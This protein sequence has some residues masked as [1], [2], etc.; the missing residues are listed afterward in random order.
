M[1]ITENKYETNID[2]VCNSAAFYLISSCSQSLAADSCILHL[3]LMHTFPTI[4]LDKS[5]EITILSLFANYC[6]SFRFMCSQFSKSSQLALTNG[7]FKLVAI[8]LEII[9]TLEYNAS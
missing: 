9:H 2:I 5:F 8:I 6:I 4:N 1:L 3:G 7:Y